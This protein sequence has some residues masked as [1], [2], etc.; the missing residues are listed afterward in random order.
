M[1]N[2]LFVRI[3]VLCFVL[4]GMAPGQAENSS[5]PKP[6]T[7]SGSQPAPAA[8]EV[9]LAPYSGMYE[10]L[11]EGEF[12]QL[13]VEDTGQVKGFVSRYAEEDAD[14]ASF[15]D[16][17]FKDATLDGNQLTFTTKTERGVW[18]EFKGTVER[19]EGKKPGDEAY[20][21]LKGTLTQNTTEAAGKVSSHAQEVTFKMFPQEASSDPAAKN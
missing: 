9:K 19:G 4:A 3:V 13:S 17:F 1:R 16:Q 15:V 12:V 21:V 14:N 7:K 10:F 11:K 18:F 8:K 6:Q 2:A 20:Y 5:Q